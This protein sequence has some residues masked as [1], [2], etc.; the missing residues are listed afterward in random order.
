MK[1]YLL[2]STI[3]VGVAAIIACVFAYARKQNRGAE[4]MGYVTI[5]GAAQEGLTPIVFSPYYCGPQENG[6][7]IRFD[8][9]HTFVG[10]DEYSGADLLDSVRKWKAKLFLR[11]LVIVAGPDEQYGK[12]AERADRFRKLGFDHIV[13]TTPHSFLDT[14]HNRD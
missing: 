14:L 12:M 9:E 4:V 11:V 7:E 1:K 3:F 10:G 8:R 6:L 2:I 13:L 5:N